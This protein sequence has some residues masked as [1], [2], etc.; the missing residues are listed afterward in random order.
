MYAL[1][2]DDAP[3][4]NFF[5]KY[6]MTISQVKIHP[7]GAP[8]IPP[9]TDVSF[10]HCS[11][12][13]K[14]KG[15]VKW[16]VYDFEN[17]CD[18]Y[19]IKG[20]RCGK[21]N[22]Q[23]FCHMCLGESKGKTCSTCKGR[24]NGRYV[25][26]N[27]PEEDKMK[28]HPSISGEDDRFD[29]GLLGEFWACYHERIMA[30][31]NTPEY[32]ETKRKWAR[33]HNWLISGA[34]D[35]PDDYADIFPKEAQNRNGVIRISSSDRT[36]MMKKGVSAVCEDVS[37]CA[38]YRTYEDKDES[39]RN[40]MYRSLKVPCGSCRRGRKAKDCGECDGTKFDARSLEWV[41]KVRV[42][43]G[44]DE[45]Q[46]NRCYGCHQDAQVIS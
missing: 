41:F 10:Y 29:F 25:K 36:K 3:G 32:Q 15:T 37:C 23:I 5:E 38:Q 16:G 17:E 33:F 9:N 28:I 43:Q 21:G 22:D 40:A 8:A 34:R 26:V 6:G 44:E 4:W 18:A 11:Q 42:P 2:W 13:T 35:I 31:K 46:G 24:G 27:M 20:L 14:C 1:Q 12:E 30:V 39:V 45:L 19:V 7:L